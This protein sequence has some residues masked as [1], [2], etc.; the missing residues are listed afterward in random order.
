VH[1]GGRATID[2]LEHIDEVV[3]RVD[4]VQAAGDQ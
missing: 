1:L 4:G 2:A 3:V